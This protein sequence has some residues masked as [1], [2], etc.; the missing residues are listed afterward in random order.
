VNALNDDIVERILSIDAVETVGV[1]RGGGGFMG[2]GGGGG[3]N[4]GDAST[5]YILLKDERSLSNKEVEQLIYENTEDLGGEMS[6]SASNMDISAFGGS[7]IQVKVEGFDPDEMAVLA[8]DVA[9]VL[10]ET[11]GTEDVTTGLED[12][13]EEIRITVDKVK[14]IREGLTVA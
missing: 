11:E 3:T 2:F 10:S 13:G 6:V 8:N 12:A 5:F 9:K 14:A 4:N 1:I 7:G